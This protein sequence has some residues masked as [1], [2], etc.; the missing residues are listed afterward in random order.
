MNFFEQIKPAFLS[1]KLAEG[2]DFTTEN[3]LLV[4]TASYLK[5]R[6]N[7]CKNGCRNCPFGF[8][9]STRATRE[10]GSKTASESLQD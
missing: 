3:G 4:F 2:K 10:N 9:K 5:R 8:N 6:G 7:C 1:E